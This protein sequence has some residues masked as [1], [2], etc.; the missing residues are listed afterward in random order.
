MLPDGL[1]DSKV[2]E[3]IVLYHITLGRYPST[4][5]IS[6]DLAWRDI[7]MLNGDTVTVVVSDTGGVT[8]NGDNVIGPD[9]F[10]LD[11]VVHIIDAVLIPPFIDLGLIFPDHTTTAGTK[12][13][14]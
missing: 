6:G 3:D 12:E 10:V 4:A 2:I 5:L 14:V 9:N 11:G 8:V 7:E 13:E 1:P